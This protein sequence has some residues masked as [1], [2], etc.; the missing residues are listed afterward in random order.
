MSI[1]LFILFFIAT[2]LFSGSLVLLTLFG[3]NLVKNYDYKIYS[4]NQFYFHL[5]IAIFYVF[6]LLYFFV[7]LRIIT[8]RKF[9]LLFYIRRIERLLIEKYFIFTAEYS[10]GI[11]YF[12]WYL[13]IIVL[14]SLMYFLLFILA[15]KIIQNSIIRIHYI[16]YSYNN[17]YLLSPGSYGP[18]VTLIDRL[19]YLDGKYILYKSDFIY[20]VRLGI[21]VT[22]WKKVIV[23]IHDSMV[24]PLCRSGMKHKAILFYSYLLV[25]LVLIYEILF[26]DG[27]LFLLFKIFPFIFTIQLLQKIR[28]VINKGF[29]WTNYSY[30]YYSSWR[31]YEKDP[32]KMQFIEEFFYSLAVLSYLLQKVLDFFKIERISFYK[33]VDNNS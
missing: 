32:A 3:L 15:L 28:E 31:I 9:N 24:M 25:V 5:I 11:I 22:K 27:S 10:V 26:H 21:T 17:T 16:M 2:V 23:Y 13:L 4:W 33:L 1:I 14:I 18:Y 6:Y 29:V 7:Y 8:E 12:I 20:D 30:L 19:F